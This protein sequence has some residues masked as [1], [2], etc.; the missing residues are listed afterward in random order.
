[1]DKNDVITVVAMSGEYVG[2]L[3]E[4]TEG[5]ITL[6]DPRMLVHN[7][8]GMGFAHGIAVTGLADPREVTFQTYVFATETNEEVQKAYTSA[9]SGIIL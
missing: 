2:K 8:Q 6:K 7:E 1:M 5:T 4:K 3:K 9:T